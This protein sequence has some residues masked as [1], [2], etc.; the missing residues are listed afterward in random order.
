ML[1]QS[2]TPRINDLGWDV[3]LDNLKLYVIAPGYKIPADEL[4][5]I[6]GVESG[7]FSIKVVLI[8]HDWYVDE[9]V[10]IV[11]MIDI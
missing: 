4:R 11:D 9:E 3:D 5:M 2:L 8:N 10:R 6:N 1:R 7:F